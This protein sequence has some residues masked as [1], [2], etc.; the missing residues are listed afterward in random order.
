MYRR[1]FTGMSPVTHWSSPIQ[2]HAL[3]GTDPKVPST[4]P[5]KHRASPSDSGPLRGRNLPFRTWV[6]AIERTTRARG[7][8]VIAVGAAQRG[9]LVKPRSRPRRTSSSRQSDTKDAYLTSRQASGWEESAIALSIGRREDQGL[10]PRKYHQNTVD[11]PADPN[12]L[13]ITWP[14]LS[15]GVT[16]KVRPSR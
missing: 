6:S 15:V 11:R 12:R 16:S 8:L 13:S 5:I 14:A 3:D 9:L 1:A 10:A 4:S 7:V 2:P